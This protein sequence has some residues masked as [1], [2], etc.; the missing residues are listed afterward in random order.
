MA[1]VSFFQNSSSNSCFSCSNSL[2]QLRLSPHLVR[3][4]GFS[5]FISPEKHLVGFL[6][7]LLGGISRPVGR[8]LLIS[9]GCMLLHISPIGSTK[10]SW[11]Q[12]NGK[13][14]R[15]TNCLISLQPLV[16]PGGRLKDLRHVQTAIHTRAAIRPC[17]QE[18]ANHLDVKTEW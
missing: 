15:N 12:M 9:P 18:R 17:R 11:D 8:I 1:C 13:P 2:R 14:V 4:Q 7:C 6:S 5:G 10:I 3:C 16:I